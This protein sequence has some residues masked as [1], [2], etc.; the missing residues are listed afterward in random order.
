MNAAMERALLRIAGS[1]LFRKVGVRILNGRATIF[2]L[3]RLR[4]DTTGAGGHTMDEMLEAIEVLRRTGAT[5]A[6][7]QDFVAAA[8][9]GT[10]REHTIIFTIDDGFAD[11]GVIAEQL[12][13]VGVPSTVFLVS[14]FL[15]GEIWPWDDRLTWAIRQSKLPSIQVDVFADGPRVFDIS[16]KAVRQASLVAIRDHL[17]ATSQEN[18]YDAVAAVAAAGGV[19]IPDAPPADYLPMSWDDVRRLEQLGVDFAAHSRTHRIFSQLETETSRAEIMHSVARVN[20][21][22]TRRVPLFAWP[23]G[24]EQDYTKRDI[25]FLR[26]AG[27]TGCVATGA[28]YATFDAAS[29][30]EDALYHLQRFGLPYRMKYTL[31]Y[32]SWIE[33]FKQ[34]IR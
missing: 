11:Q 16:N 18:V 14:G 21:E 12:I 25:Q 20:E 30:D 22:T 19:V 33:R 27:I 26:E 2:M 7:L 29:G 23:T 10:A 1:P 4:D 28:D 13:R 9:N 5:F 15:D 24:L 17:K 32:G 34:L 6:R 3:H 8:R 31:Q